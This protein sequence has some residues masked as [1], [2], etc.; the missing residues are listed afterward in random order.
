MTKS[1]P[2]QSEDVSP[3]RRN[4][5][6]GAFV[7]ISGAAVLASS[8]KQPQAQAFVKW[9]AGKGGQ[10]ILRIGDAFDYA[11]GVGAISHPSLEPLDK[12]QAP[13]IEPS[14]LNSKAVSDLMTAAGLL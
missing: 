8:K 5:D 14:K 4:G 7:S 9:V 3:Q 13:K 1:V 11:L 10:E 12:L 2:L 6:A